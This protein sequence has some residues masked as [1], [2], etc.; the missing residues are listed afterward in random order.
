MRV[1]EVFKLYLKLGSLG[2]VANEM[3]RRGWRSK[4]RVTKAGKQLRGSALG[5]SKVQ[6]L[7]TSVLYRG[8]IP[9]DGDVFEGR[10]DAIIDAEMWE[11]VQT[12]LRRNR[13]AAEALSVT[14]GACS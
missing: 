14:N 7:L 5:K 11:S 12:Q 13:R 2:E 4:D 3:T 8:K 1:R 9:Y 6:R 10:H